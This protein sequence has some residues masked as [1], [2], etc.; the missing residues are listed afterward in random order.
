M[1]TEITVIVL[2]TGLNGLFSMSE[3]AVISARASRLSAMARRGDARASAALALGAQPENFLATVQIGITLIGIFAGAYGGVTLTEDVIALFEFWG[4]EGMYRDDVAMVVV[5]TGITLLS[6]VI[7][8][9]APKRIALAHAETIARFAARPMRALSIGAA[10][11]VWLLGQ[12]TRAVLWLLRIRP[13]QVSEVTEEEIRHMI[14]IG[15]AGGVIRTEERELLE[16]VFRFGDRSVMEIMIPF[17]DMVMLPLD[18][19]ARDVTPVLAATPYSHY[20][21]FDG[22]RGNVVGYV[23]TT[24]LLATCLSRPEAM[25]DPALLAN[26]LQ[27]AEFIPSSLSTHQALLRF[28]RDRV[29]VL[30]V[31]DEHGNVEGMI[32]PAEIASDVVGDA[33]ISDAELVHRQDGSLLV[34]GSLPMRDFLEHV[35]SAFLPEWSPGE[36]FTVAGYVIDRLGRIPTEGDVV[37]DAGL[38][39]EVMDMDGRRVDKL[40]VTIDPRPES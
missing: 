1:L 38:R 16:N 5:V 8:E 12:C 6:L 26:A 21:V 17:A 36:Y 19:S 2:L 18:A 3:I 14:S 34:D 30:F 7:G 27:E 25:T 37:I 32:T 4:I 35:P 22:E 13:T 23:T 29:R 24:G 28:R 40:L 11:V 20:P 33:G 31:V 39:I 10:P 9:L 15:A